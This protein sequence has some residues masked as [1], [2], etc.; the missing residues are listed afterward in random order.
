MAIGAAFSA[1]LL[2]VFAG[3]EAP[4][5]VG[6][7]PHMKASGAPMRTVREWGFWCALFALVGAY[8]VALT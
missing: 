8:I 5:R 7:Q 3:F 6:T 4:V 1:A 2:L